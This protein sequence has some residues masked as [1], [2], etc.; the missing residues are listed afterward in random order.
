MKRVVVTGL[1]IV[2]CIGNTKDDVV[3]SLKNLKSGII[4]A[5]E[6]KEFGFRSLVH[7]KPIINL[8]DLIDRNS[9]DIDALINLADYYS[10]QGENQKSIDLLDSLKQKDKESYIVKMLRLKLKIHLDNSLSD[11]IKDEFDEITK[12]MINMTDDS[13]SLEL[14]DKDFKWLNENGEVKY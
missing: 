2:S 14:K 12:E 6:Y 9:N 7:G 1:G 8:K 5:P 4:K 3:N 10:N 13:L 11:V